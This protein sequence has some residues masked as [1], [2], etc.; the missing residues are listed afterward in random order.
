MTEKYLPRS[1][2]LQEGIRRYFT[3]KPCVNGHISYRDTS[4]RHCIECRNIRQAKYR[5]DN[6]LERRLATRAWNLRNPEKHAEN[7]RKSVRSWV[8]KFPEKAA[9]IKSARDRSAKLAFVSW[10]DRGK[11]AAIY[12]ERNRR[13]AEGSERWVVDHIVPLRSKIVCGLHNEFNLAVVL[14]SDNSKKSNKFW[15]DMPT[16]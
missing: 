11:M 1:I 2:A 8:Q 5:S 10:A 7:R 12:A 14:A 4:D 9:A 16:N 6:A 3:G 13:N 15:P